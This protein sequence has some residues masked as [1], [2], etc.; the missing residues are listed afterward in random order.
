MSATEIRTVFIEDVPAD[1][2]P[3]PT[4]NPLEV[5]AWRCPNGSTYVQLVDQTELTWE[6]Y[7]ACLAGKATA[8]REIIGKGVMI[9]EGYPR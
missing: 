7:C 6:S 4:S 3:I 1:Y 8:L 9:V 2:V 5:A